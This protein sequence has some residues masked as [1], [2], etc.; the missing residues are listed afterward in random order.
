[1]APAIVVG[2][3]AAA[4]LIPMALDLLDKGLNPSGEPLTEQ[5]IAELRALVDQQH[6]V[7]QALEG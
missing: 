1:M 2:I 7:V 3:Q 6:A 4:I 5:Q